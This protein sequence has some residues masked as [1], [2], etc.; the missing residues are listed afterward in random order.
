MRLLVLLTFLLWSFVH[1]ADPNCSRGLKGA[2]N[3]CCPSYCRTCGGSGCETRPGSFFECCTSGVKQKN[4]SC[5]QYEA[6]CTMNQQQ[7][8]QGQQPQQQPTGNIKRAT[9][10]LMLPGPK[11]G[12]FDREQ[13]YGTKLDGILFYSRA[14]RMD[15]RWIKNYLDA[16]RHVTYVI[17]FTEGGYANLNSIRYGKYDAQIR[18][19]AKDAA[20]DGRRFHIRIMH[21]FDGNWYPWCIFRGG[22]NSLEGYKA[23]YRR[24][25][26]ILRSEKVNAKYQQAYNIR[27]S[28]K[29]YSVKDMYIGDNYADQ[30]CVSVY[31][32]AGSSSYHKWTSLDTLL[33]PWY[34]EMTTVTSRPLC[35][36]ETSAPSY[37]GDKGKWL[38]DA[39]YTIATKFSRI[40]EVT[41]FFE[42]KDL[43]FDLNKQSEI[44]GFRDGFYNFKRLTEPNDNRKLQNVNITISANEDK[45]E[46]EQL[47]READISYRNEQETAILSDEEPIDRES[48]AIAPEDE[49]FVSQYED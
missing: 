14:N 7:Q 2:D 4:R 37:R 31:N 24:V 3:T 8:Q 26:D 40:T 10:I 1:A 19:F 34:N 27:P 23:A 36:S 13:K 22:S 33:T 21:E 48:K 38:K 15:F 44:D 39:F 49:G 45:L 12:Y 28:S 47:Q 42:N 16:G 9:K 30:V 32:R 20:K 11:L 46:Q 5:D 6:P 18:K 43:Q 35:I 41:W 29:R 25:V 17:E